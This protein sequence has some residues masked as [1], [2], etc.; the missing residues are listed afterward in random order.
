MFGTAAFSVQSKLVVDLYA[1]WRIFTTSRPADATQSTP[2]STPGYG[3][4][5]NTKFCPYCDQVMDESLISV[6]NGITLQRISLLLIISCFS[7]PLD[8]IRA[9]QAQW[10]IWRLES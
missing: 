9:W 2:V 6:G 1:F 4:K 10:S 7:F 3:W 5:N 8:Q